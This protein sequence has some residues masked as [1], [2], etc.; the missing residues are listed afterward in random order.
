LPTNTV[1]ITVEVGSVL[2]SPSLINN[3]AIRMCR[4][5]GEVMLKTQP[6]LLHHHPHLHAVH[7]V[8][9]NK[10]LMTEYQRYK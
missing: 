9:T 6:L 8:F 1:A 5:K 3:M 7:S 10:A 4:V 2:T